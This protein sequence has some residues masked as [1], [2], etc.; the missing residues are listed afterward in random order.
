MNLNMNSRIENYEISD[1]VEMCNYLQEIVDEHFS[2]KLGNNNSLFKNFTFKEKE[3]NVSVSNMEK[4]RN[5]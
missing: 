2:Q 4:L 3:S 1:S 5:W